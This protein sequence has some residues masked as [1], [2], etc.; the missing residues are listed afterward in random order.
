MNGG[1]GANGFSPGYGPSHAGPPVGLLQGAVG[2]SSVGGLSFTPATPSLFGVG[3]SHMDSGLYGGGVGVSPTKQRMQK[4]I[5]DQ[6]VNAR[7]SSNIRMW[8]VVMG[9]F[10]PK[11][12]KPSLQGLMFDSIEVTDKV[13]DMLLYFRGFDLAAFKPR[14]ATGGRLPIATHLTLMAG[15]FITIARRGVANDERAAAAASRARVDSVEDAFT[16]VIGEVERHARENYVAMQEQHNRDIILKAHVKGMELFERDVGMFS[17]LVHRIH[18]L[19]PPSAAI[20]AAPVPGSPTSRRISGRGG[21]INSAVQGKTDRRVGCCGGRQCGQGV[22]GVLPVYA[23]WDL[24]VQGEMPLQACGEKEGRWG[25]RER[26][27]RTRW[28]RR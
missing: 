11:I 9:C 24:P 10:P 1:A 18:V 17:D 16:T 7:N 25:E 15:S 20:L 21:L 3:A 22:A 28:A 12:E 13:A 4:V 6:R 14:G 26:R 8:W 27:G 2:R 23:T 19:H 5:T